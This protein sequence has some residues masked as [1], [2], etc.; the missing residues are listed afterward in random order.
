[1]L[2]QWG[3]IDGAP[4]GAGT[5]AAVEEYRKDS[6]GGGYCC[7]SGEILMALLREQTLL[8]QWG[9]MGKAPAGASTAAAVRKYR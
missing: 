5:A 8:R 9:S 7:G 4:A 2:R 3:D 1:M 6:C